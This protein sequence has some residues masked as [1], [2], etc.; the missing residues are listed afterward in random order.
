MNAVDHIIRLSSVDHHRHADT[1]RRDAFLSC[2]GHLHLSVLFVVFKEKI[3]RIYRSSE[4]PPVR[5]KKMATRRTRH[6]FYFYCLISSGRAALGE[7]ACAAILHLRF[8]SLFFS[9]FSRPRAGLATHSAKYFFF[10][11][12]TDTLN[13]TNNNQQQ[14]PS[15]INSLIGGHFTSS[16]HYYLLTGCCMTPNRSSDGTSS[17]N[18]YPIPINTARTLLTVTPVYYM[19]V[20]HSLGPLL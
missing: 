16:S 19:N 14:S 3:E 11:L 4:H 15:K 10:G 18:L 9:L 20:Y 7:G 17:S 6:V 12:A 2:S 13:M 1:S 5:G 8:C